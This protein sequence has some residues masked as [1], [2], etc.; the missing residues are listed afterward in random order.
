M[1]TC[2]NCLAMIRT[3]PCWGGKKKK[4]SNL[5]H[6]DDRGLPQPDHSLRNGLSHWARLVSYWI[7]DVHCGEAAPC[8]Q[9]TALINS[10]LSTPTINVWSILCAHGICIPI[11]S[12][13][14]E[15]I[16]P[17]TSFFLKNDAARSTE[18]HPVC[19]RHSSVLWHRTRSL[20]RWPLI[21]FCSTRSR[22]VVIRWWKTSSNNTLSVY[23]LWRPI[24]TLASIV[25]WLVLVVLMSL[26]SSSNLRPKGENQFVTKINEVLKT[27]P[28]FRKTLHEWW[29]QSLPSAC[30]VCHDETQFNAQRK[31]KWDEQLASV[32][33]YQ[34]SWTHWSN[35]ETYFLCLIKP[36]NQKK[37][38]EKCLPHLILPR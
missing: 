34:H 37:F 35:L 21:L 30:F 25:M 29:C 33:A 23:W 38:F 18:G 36:S 11:V 12:T 24:S 6:G 7:S 5:F 1:N 14:V 26:N 8:L 22:A 17:W 15:L 28:L 3:G 31:R 9:R 20:R 19:V 4:K 27:H 10:W 2:R 32:H 16:T 13:L